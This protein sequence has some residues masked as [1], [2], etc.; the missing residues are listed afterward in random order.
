[1]RRYSS[2]TRDVIPLE[3]GDGFRTVVI[4]PNLE[5]AQTTVGALPTSIDGDVPP[6]AKIGWFSQ[7]SPSGL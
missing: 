7:Y 3:L 4:F 2:R 5:V 1:M 6:K